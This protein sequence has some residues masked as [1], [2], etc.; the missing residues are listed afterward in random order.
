MSSDIP[1]IGEVSSLVVC[2]DHDLVAK[3]KGRNKF[4]CPKGHYVDAKGERRPRTLT[5]VWR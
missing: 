3:R 4:H 1:T 5:E 2:K